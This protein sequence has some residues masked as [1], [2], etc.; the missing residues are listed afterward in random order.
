VRGG[1]PGHVG[2][3]QVGSYGASQATPGRGVASGVAHRAT[4]WPSGRTCTAP[5]GSRPGAAAVWGG[6]AATWT[7]AAKPVCLIGAVNSPRPLQPPH[8]PYRTV[9]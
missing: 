8:L 3:D 1:G 6:R 2:A 9:S 5:A 7:S 4:S